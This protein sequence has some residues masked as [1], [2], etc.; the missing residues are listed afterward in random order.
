MPGPATIHSVSTRSQVLKILADAQFHSGTALGERLGISRAA[1]NKAIKQLGESGLEFDRISGRG[2]RLSTPL[3]VLSAEAIASAYARADGRAHAILPQ[4]YFAARLSVLDDTPSTSDHILALDPVQRQGAVCIAE[5]QRAGRGRRGRSWIAAP[6]SNIMMSMGWRFEG[7]VARLA[8]LSLAIAVAVARALEQFGVHDHGLKWPNDVMWGGRKLAGLL[9]ELQGE[10]T[11]PTEVV[12][13]LGLNVR[14]GKMGDAI[15]QPH[16]DLAEI[17]AMTPDRN[18]LVAAL[19]AE[20]ACACARFDAEGFA[21]FIKPWQSLHV[22][23]GREVEIYRG[24]NRRRG[25]A[26]GIDETGALRLRTT[27]G[28]IELM[29]SGEVSLRGAS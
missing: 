25:I 12:I 14:M 4:S 8:G 13:G 21:P 6:Y 29:H 9:I 16:V 5:H 28:K 22:H 26:E 20:L 24:E 1:V 3:S 15:D 18:A 2:Y 27:A 23:Q 7:G 17:L 11:G 19:A 10:S